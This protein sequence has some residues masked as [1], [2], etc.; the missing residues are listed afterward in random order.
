MRFVSNV[1][2]KSPSCKHT[3]G[4]AKSISA[5]WENLQV[6]IDVAFL[7]QESDGEKSDQDLVVDDANE[8]STGATCLLRFTFHCDTSTKIDFVR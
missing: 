6:S 2:K 8:V 4:N 7:F 3:A 1:H 5:P